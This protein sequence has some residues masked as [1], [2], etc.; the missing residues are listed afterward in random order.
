MADFYTVKVESNRALTPEMRLITLSGGPADLYARYTV[1]GQYLQVAIGEGKPGFFA[2][3]S[4]PGERRFELLIKRSPGL[5]EELHAI[6]PGGEVR[7][8][9]PAG[10]GYVIADHEGKDLLLLAQGSGL[11]PIRAVIKSLVGGPQLGKVR[12]FVGIRTL[13]DLAF[14]EESKSWAA[15]GVEIVHCL[16]GSPAEA[17]GGPGHH[18]G[19]IQHVLKTLGGTGRPTVVCLCG[20]KDM[21]AECR[22]VL[23]EHGVEADAVL[24]NF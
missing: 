20:N 22:A 11:A 12:L 18:H 23:A 7:V 10:K 16:S 3:A 1:P 2:I 13:Q 21:M 17:S 4:A 24:T 15:D 14:S 8:S 9:A 19:Y 5:A 6:R